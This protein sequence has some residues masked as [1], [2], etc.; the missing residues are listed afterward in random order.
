MI[1]HVPS[2]FGG[3]KKYTLGDESVQISIGPVL[4]IIPAQTW[5]VPYEELGLTKPEI[6][7]GIFRMGKGELVQD[8][9]PNLSADKRERLLTPATMSNV[10]EEAQ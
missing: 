5:D 1:I 2:A 10:F 6:K 4:G 9:F 8:V 3:S 7:T